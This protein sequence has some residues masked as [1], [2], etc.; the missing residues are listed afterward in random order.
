MRLKTTHKDLSGHMLACG[1][2]CIQEIDYKSLFDLVPGRVSMFDISLLE[3][4]R[5]RFFRTQNSS[6]NRVEHQRWVGVASIEKFNQN[7]S[8]HAFK[9]IL[10]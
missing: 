6:G 7:K 8:D 3:E 9:L 10:V 4:E 2:K 1:F 5:R